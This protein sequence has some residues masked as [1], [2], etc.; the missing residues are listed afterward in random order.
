MNWTI[1][2]TPEIIYRRLGKRI[3]IYEVLV[4]AGF[5]ELEFLGFL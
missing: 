5:A 1:H 3:G 2:G 4:G